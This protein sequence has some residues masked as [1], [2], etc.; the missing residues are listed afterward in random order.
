MHVGKCFVRA[1]QHYY[2]INVGQVTIP[3]LLHDFNIH[4]TFCRMTNLF[5]RATWLLCHIGSYIIQ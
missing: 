3:Y 1:V 4:L 2:A 5:Y